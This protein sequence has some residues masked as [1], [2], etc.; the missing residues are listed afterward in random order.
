MTFQYM[1]TGHGRVKCERPE[2][3]EFLVPGFQHAITENV[4]PGIE[5]QQLYAFQ[6]LCGLFQTVCRVVLTE[7]GF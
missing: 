1:L 2:A 3:G 4:L 5:L 7:S 6:D